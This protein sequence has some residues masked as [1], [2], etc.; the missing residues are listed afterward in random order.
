M[1]EATKN[2]AV[3]R[4]TRGI[5]SSRMRQAATTASS[6]TR[7]NPAA[8]VG[9]L[10]TPPAMWTAQG[11]GMDRNMILVVSLRWTLWARLLSYE[12]HNRH[13]SGERETASGADPNG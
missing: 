6:P 2:A 13:T 8:S 4:A 7:T 10:S 11:R 12:F 9:Q 1:D 3:N 5:S